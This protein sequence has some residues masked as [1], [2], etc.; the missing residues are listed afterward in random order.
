MVIDKNILL[1]FD[2]FIIYF[3]G[4]YMGLEKIF[5]VKHKIV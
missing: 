4:K 1:L 2:I 5:D 3:Q